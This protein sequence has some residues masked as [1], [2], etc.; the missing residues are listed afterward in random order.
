VLEKKLMQV[1]KRRHEEW[2]AQIRR[3]AGQLFPRGGLQERTL[4]ILGYEARYGPALLDR[5]KKAPH[6]PG[7]HPLVP[8]GVDPGR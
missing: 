8:I 5:L 1:W 7:A 4:S 2:V 6:E 3:A